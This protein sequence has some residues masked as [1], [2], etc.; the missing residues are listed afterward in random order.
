VSSLIGAVDDKEVQFLITQLKDDGLF[1][2]ASKSNKQVVLSLKG[3]KAFSEHQQS[4][5]S[6]YSIFMAMKFRDV[7]L[8]QV[9]ERSINPAVEAAGF[10]F[11][12]MIED[13]RAGL[14]DEKIKS[15][16]E[17]ANLVIADI[18]HGSQNA[19]WEAGFA[20]GAGK[21]VLYTCREDTLRHSRFNTRNHLTLSWKPEALEEFG[22]TVLKSFCRPRTIQK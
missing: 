5:T 18:T 15:E 7:E 3:W 12:C 6:T 4:K 22:E 19:Y 2:V 17:R 14:I 1:E 9:V 20:H 16:I 11:V 21:P 10:E 8:E 13:L